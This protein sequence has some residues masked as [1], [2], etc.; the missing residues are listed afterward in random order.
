MVEPYTGR[1]LQLN[2]G[3]RRL[4]R[5]IVMRPTA[6]ALLLVALGA[7]CAGS[8]RRDTGE[9]P[10][11]R[12]LPAGWP[13][14]TAYVGPDS[15]VFTFAV[16]FAR[17]TYHWSVAGPPG[18]PV[19]RLDI[20]F[21]RSIFERDVVLSWVV[22]GDEEA[23]EGPLSALL[24]AGHGELSWRAPCQG[25]IVCMRSGLLP[26]FRAEASSDGR[27]VRLV[28][29]DRDVLHDLRNLLEAKG[30]ERVTFESVGAVP[31]GPRTQQVGLRS[32]PGSH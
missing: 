9:R 31:V 11:T 8:A 2:T 12:R 10:G 20:A 5:A 28:L 25:S 32:A 7:S 22:P 1:P 18:A 17:D 15:A 6:A 3:V 24:A 19:L 23:H 30:I 26:A 16:E 21:G 4:S 14:P 29:A 13:E 27:K